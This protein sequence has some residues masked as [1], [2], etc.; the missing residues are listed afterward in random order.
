M[1]YRKDMFVNLNGVDCKIID[2]QYDEYLNEEY[3]G[4]YL[5]R[6]KDNSKLVIIVDHKSEDTIKILE[7]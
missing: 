4:L 3:C 1:K 2:V 5:E 7:A 6:V